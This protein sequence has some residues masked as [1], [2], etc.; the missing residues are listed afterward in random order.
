[1]DL[2]D[3]LAKIRSKYWESYGSAKKT[4]MQIENIKVFYGLIEPYLKKVEDNLGKT[5][6]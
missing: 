6:K 2:K 3:D 1:M 5:N 4:A